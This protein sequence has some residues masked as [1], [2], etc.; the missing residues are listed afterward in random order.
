ME[1]KAILRALEKHRGKRR[2]A[3]KELKI[4]ERTL[5]RKIREYGLD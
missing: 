5:Y 4:S 3:A 1:K 2:D